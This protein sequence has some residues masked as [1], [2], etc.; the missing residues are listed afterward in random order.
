MRILLKNKFRFTGCIDTPNLTENKSKMKTGIVGWFRLYIT[1]IGLLLFQS[2]DA[3]ELIYTPMNPSFGGNPNNGTILMNEAT[4]QNPFKAPS[5]ALTPMQTFQNN[6]QNAILTNL[7]TQIKNS[8]FGT[9]G[10]TINPGTYD[11]G[12]YTVTV[13]DNGNGTLSILT[14]DNTTGATAQFDLSQTKP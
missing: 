12:N 7:T 11:A 3:S 5:T 6:L 2:A 13:T 4:A 10:N 9:N 14:K 8:M 1:V